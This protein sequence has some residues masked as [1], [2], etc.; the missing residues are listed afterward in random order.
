MTLSELDPGFEDPS[1]EFELRP[2][3]A[4]DVESAEPPDI[5]AEQLEIAG[6][7]ALLL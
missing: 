7:F 5:Q 2:S 1:F 6:E 3:K 4:R